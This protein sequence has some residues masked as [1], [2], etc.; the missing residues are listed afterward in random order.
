MCLD[1]FNMLDEL[2]ELLA[3]RQQADIDSL[4][5]QSMDAQSN[6]EGMIDTSTNKG[7]I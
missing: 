4:K 5:A 6:K 3:E 2:L 7:A 1:L